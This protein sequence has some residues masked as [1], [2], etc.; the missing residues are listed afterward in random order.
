MLGVANMQQA[1][2]MVR[3]PFEVGDII[4]GDKSETRYMILDILH[5]YSMMEKTVVDVSFKVRNLVT[6]KEEV[7]KYDSDEWKLIK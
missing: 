5:T 6:D 7:I 3:I 4:I 1:F 2:Y